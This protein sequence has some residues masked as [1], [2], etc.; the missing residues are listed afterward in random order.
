M[1]KGPRRNDRSLANILAGA[2]DS[3][4][5][6]NPE[7][8]ARLAPPSSK[9]KHNKQQA[10]ELP[11]QDKKGM[12]KAS[13]LVIAR[14]TRRGKRKLD[15]DNMS[16]GCKQL[17]DAIAQ[18]LFGLKGDTREDGIE[19]EYAQEISKTTT[20]TLVEFWIEPQK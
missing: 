18:D 17:R 16:G 5:K 15:D 9:Q 12:V 1:T 8:V 3:F 4:W 20:D 14:I 2:S 6:V 7:L 10:L 19:F 11:A 13:G